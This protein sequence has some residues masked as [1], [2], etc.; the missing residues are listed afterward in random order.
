MDRPRKIALVCACSLLVVLIVVYLTRHRPRTQLSV[1]SRPGEF[2]RLPASVRPTPGRGGGVRIVAAPGSAGTSTDA[3]IYCSMFPGSRIVYCDA[4]SAP[5]HPELARPAGVNLYV[6]HAFGLGRGL[7]PSRAKWLMVN[8]EMLVDDARLA[9]VDLFLCKSAYARRLMDALIRERGWGSATILTK[10]T[11]RDLAQTPAPRKK[12]PRL[13]LHMAGKSWLKNT[14]AVLEAWIRDFATSDARLLFTCGDTC[15]DRGPGMDRWLSLFVDPVPV[16]FP[17]T[18]PLPWGWNFS[19]AARIYACSAA[20]NLFWCRGLAREDVDMLHRCASVFV[21]PSSAEGY[22]HYINEARSAG[23]A[24]VTVDAPPMNELVTSAN[25]AL[26]PPASRHC[27]SLFTRNYTTIPGSEGVEVRPE[28]L[29]AALRRLLGLPP[30]ELE[31]L[32]AES[33]RMFDRDTAECLRALGALRA[34]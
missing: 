6:E 27:S 30:G 22:G 2:F 33:R 18:L 31:K 28:D 13:V 32:G 14:P 20:P 26:V 34:A 17:V 1:V 9:A 19:G 3:E 10:H 7:L 25:G 15:V 8:Q 16:L 11:S 21:C 29:S 12:D 5:G 23:G 24:V 4:S